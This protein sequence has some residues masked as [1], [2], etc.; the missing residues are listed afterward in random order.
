MY[1]INTQAKSLHCH[2]INNIFS[3]IC[4]NYLQAYKQKCNINTH[5][6]THTHTPTHTHTH[7]QAHALKM[8]KVNLLALL[9]KVKSLKFKSHPN[10]KNVGK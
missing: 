4:H 7:T 9:A 8:H 2:V 6:H 3:S 5:T 1:N 10:L